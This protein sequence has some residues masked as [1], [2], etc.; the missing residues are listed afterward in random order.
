MPESSNEQSA[1]A[2]LDWNEAGE[3]VSTLFEDT[4]Y[5]KTNGQAE[6][7]F[8]F[9]QNNNLLARWQKSNGLRIAELGFGTGLNLLELWRQWKTHRRVGDMLTFESLEG[10]PMLKQ[11]MA[12]ALKAWDNL[13]EEAAI[14][15]AQLPDQWPEAPSILTL[16][17]D[18]QT[19]LIL[20]MGMAENVIENFGPRQQAW[21]FDGF[22]PARNE[23]MWTPALMK[24]V[25]DKTDIGGTFATYTSA[26]W[27]RRNL[28]DAGFYVEKIKG[29]AGK[30]AMTIGH[31]PA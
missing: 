6:T 10:F 12:Q 22:S 2:Q 19:T 1:S 3:P 21:F 13:Q 5:S 27:V 4:Y 17:L 7:D 18:T 23:G 14:L 30:R 28:A 26:G 20:H 8:V 15:L 16:E 31:K 25:F 24:S 9:I 11:D 29:Y